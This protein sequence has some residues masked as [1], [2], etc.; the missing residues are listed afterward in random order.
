MS[1]NVQT[2]VCCD[3]CACKTATERKKRAV[4]VGQTE[5]VFVVDHEKIHNKSTAQAEE[6]RWKRDVLDEVVKVDAN[7]NSE[8][9]RAIIIE[10]VDRITSV[11]KRRIQAECESSL[12]GR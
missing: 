12:N 10:N 4:Q 1:E 8:E 11:S 6:T 7:C 5:G 3:T 9:L 2:P